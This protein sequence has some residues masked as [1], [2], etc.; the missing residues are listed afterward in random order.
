MRKA[1]VEMWFSLAKW[2][3]YKA[4]ISSPKE[5]LSDKAKIK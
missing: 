2:T 5:I 3:P 1:T 4:A